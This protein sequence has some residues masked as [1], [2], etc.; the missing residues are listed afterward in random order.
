MVSPHCFIMLKPRLCWFQ[1]KW[2]RGGSIP[3]HIWLQQH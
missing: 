3:S 2:P 1:T